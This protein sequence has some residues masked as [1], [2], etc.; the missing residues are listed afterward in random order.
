MTRLRLFR[1]AIF[2]L[3]LF[4]FVD[5]AFIA[6]WDAFGAMFRY[7]TIWALTG[8]LIAAAAMLTPRYGRPD[9][10]ADGWLS[11]L[12]I[13]NALVVF[14]YWRL[15]FINPALVNGSNEIV[16]YRE[17]YLHLL[18]PALMWIDLMLIKRGF[19]RV[20]PAVAGLS[21]L[22]LAYT[23]WAELLVGPLNDAP[24]GT[25][26]SGLPYPF[27]N[28]MALPQR[29]RFYGSIFLTGLVFVAL[30]RGLAWLRDRAQPSSASRAASPE[31]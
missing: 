14:S 11:T 29:L 20:L 4:F 8:N 17:Y 1:L 15:Y 25:V 6:N 27:M 7:L 28:D 13:L 19:R 22:I 10:R 23:L 12:A 5:R 30:F 31:R 21:V 26:T 18:G 24:V 3:A 9:G 16:A 2:A